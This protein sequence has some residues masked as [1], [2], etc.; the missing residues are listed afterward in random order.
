MYTTV[1]VFALTGFTWTAETAPSWWTDYTQA[2]QQGMMEKKP[3]AVFIGTGQ[4]GWGKLAREGN[5]EKEQKDLLANRYVCVYVDVASEEGRR[6]AQRL[7]IAGGRGLVISDHSGALMA[8]HHEGD[9]AGRDLTRYLERYSDP[10]RRVLVTETNPSQ[11]TR[12]YYPPPPPAQ[13]PIRMRS[14]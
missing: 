8:F 3:V 11:Q 12:S 10:S 4:D 7:E 1:V 5:L 14:C 2:R 9:L 6:I 13:A